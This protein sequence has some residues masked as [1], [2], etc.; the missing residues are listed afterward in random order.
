MEDVAALLTVMAGSDPA[1]AAT[2]EAD[3]H[4][5]DYRT[6]LSKDALRGN[7]SASCSLITHS[8]H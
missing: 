2:T 8:I 5:T 3:A 6:T 1:D 4:I 7:G